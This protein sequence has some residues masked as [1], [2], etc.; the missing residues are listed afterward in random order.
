[1]PL[2]TAVNWHDFRDAPRPPA[3][4]LLDDDCPRGTVALREHHVRPQDV[5][6][7]HPSLGAG[8]HS[9]AYRCRV[10]L[11]DQRPSVAC[12]VKFSSRLNVSAND[13]HPPD[14]PDGC[15]AII[16]EVA[17]RDYRDELANV[18]R[19]LEPPG[20]DGYT[21]TDNDRDVLDRMREHPGFRHIHTVYHV[22]CAPEAPYPMLFSAPCE[23]TLLDHLR[24]RG[25]FPATNDTAWQDAMRQVLY[26]IS[27]IA[28]Q[29]GMVHG[30]L[31][32]GNVFVL[33]ARP[34]L[35]LVLS[36]FALCF[37]LEP[38]DRDAHDCLDET[39][40]SVLRGSLVDADR[41]RPRGHIGE[42][43]AVFDLHARVEPIDAMNTA[44][45]LLGID[46]EYYIRY[47]EA[48]DVPRRTRR[49]L[50]ESSTAHTQPHSRLG[51]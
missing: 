38:G 8:I 9:V 49:R 14:A 19:L 39:L 23:T 4:S 41:H 12:V 50:S 10:R 48:E 6:L 36:D 34:P 47:P 30:D 20:Y 46:D 44:M 5:T 27:Y 17:W 3:L 15:S 22:E 16:R 25:Y 31:H 29:A 33:D 21:V 28:S 13:V 43:A 45:R 40:G 42:W 24:R 2:L 1:M 26:G 32:L 35:R 37:L 7:E 51:L 11:D 18:R